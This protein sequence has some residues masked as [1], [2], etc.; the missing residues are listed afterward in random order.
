M[1]T[2]Y[3]FLNSK[4]YFEIQNWAILLFYIENAIWTLKTGHNA[5]F[6]TFFYVLIGVKYSFFYIQNPILTFK[7]GLNIIL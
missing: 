5:V 6:F 4:F 7:I 3:R 2:K 1:R